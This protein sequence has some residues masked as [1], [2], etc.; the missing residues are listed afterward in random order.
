MSIKIETHNKHVSEYKLKF[1]PKINTVSTWNLFSKITSEQNLSESSGSETISKGGCNIKKSTR[2]THG[3]TRHDSLDEEWNASNETESVL[4]KTPN[5]YKG[6]Y[7][8]YKKNQKTH[9]NYSD[10]DVKTSKRKNNNLFFNDD[11]TIKRFTK[12]KKRELS[13]RDDLTFICEQLLENPNLEI[14]G[15]KRGLLLLHN[16]IKKNYS[17]DILCS[18]KNMYNCNLL[19]RCKEKLTECVVRQTLEDNKDWLYYANNILLTNLNT[20][21]EKHNIINASE[22]IKQLEPAKKIDDHIKIDIL[23]PEARSTLPSL[24]SFLYGYHDVDIK[25]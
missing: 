17:D 19:H 24:S 11:N 3:K 13:F 12:V 10:D 14:F 21:L 1:Q 22:N 16:K 23:K 9:E 25:K 7:V 8:N 15:I 20:F 2:E 5:K 6:F 18:Q 4:E